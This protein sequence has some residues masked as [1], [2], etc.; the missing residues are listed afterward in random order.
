VRASAAGTFTTTLSTGRKVT[1]KVAEVPAAVTPDRWALSVDDWRPG[2]DGAG[3][4]V[5]RHSLTLD[6]LL[7]WSQIP[8]LADVG[9]IGTYRTTVTLPKS[10]SSATGALLRLG[11]VTDTCRVTVNGVRLDPVD[12]VNPVVDL[13]GHLR[14]G[15]NTLEIEVATPLFNRLRV[16]NPAVFG[17]SARQAYGLVGPVQLVPYVQRTVA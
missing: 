6:A 10:W 12:R 2:A 1:T 3:T 16:S 9:G 17:T 7:P 14:K 4:E 8:E 11:S 5:V 15:A 13:G